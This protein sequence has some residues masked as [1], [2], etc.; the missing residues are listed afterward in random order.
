MLK[1]EINK[2]D[3]LAREV[4]YKKDRCEWCG[5]K[6]VA[7]NLHH[8]YSRKFQSVRWYIPNLNL[9]CVACHFKAH[10][11]PLEFIDFLRAKLGEEGLK[12]L[13]RKA[14]KVEKQ[15]YKKWLEYLTVDNFTKKALPY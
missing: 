13:R 1:K 10:N 12:E 8:S 9:L 5:K 14:N 11:K 15:T 3:K 4:I 7:F 2:L 6:N